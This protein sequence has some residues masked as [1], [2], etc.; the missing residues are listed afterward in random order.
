MK[1]IKPKRLS[2]RKLMESAIEYLE[3]KTG[4]HSTNIRYGNGYLIDTKKDI[5]CWFEFKEIP[6]YTFAFW[7]KDFDWDSEAFG[8]E[9][10]NA[11][12]IL[13]TQ[14]D[15]TRDKFKP[16]RSSMKTPMFRW[17]F[18]DNFKD[19]WQEEWNDCGAADMIKFI[20]NHRYR[21]FY[22]Q[23]CSEWEPWEYVSGFT[24]IKEYYK[25]IVKDFIEKRKEIHKLNKIARD[26]VKHLKDIDGVRAV[27]SDYTH[28]FSPR[29]SLFIYFR[30]KDD[31]IVKYNKAMDYLEDK[32][33]N[34][35]SIT[36]LECSAEF[37]KYLN[38]REKANGKDEV[39]IWKK[40]N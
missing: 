36:Y 28:M 4:Y 2:R 26:I 19:C 20:H 17:V 40:I 14:A 39:L 21:A 30:G 3:K 34:D 7:H 9:Y 38:Y 10:A 18:K 12:L 25:T 13:F 16:S 33:W 31:S 15:I 5:V 35:L 6:G 32:Y 22:I 27:L 23:S 8:P 29:L 1:D 24:A 37:K 11:E